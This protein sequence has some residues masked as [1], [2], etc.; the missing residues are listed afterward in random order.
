MSPVAYFLILI[1]GLIL[2]ANANPP[3]D[4]DDE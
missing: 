1:L 3:D 4:S 2:L